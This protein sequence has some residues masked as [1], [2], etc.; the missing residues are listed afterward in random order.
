M[1]SEL[2][3]ICFDVPAVDD[4]GAIVYTVPGPPLITLT[5]TGGSG[6]GAFI[7]PEV[8]ATHYSND[9]GKLT[10]VYIHKE[11]SGYST[12]VSATVESP[13]I[14]TRGV[15]SVVGSGAGVS[16]STTSGGVTQVNVTNN[17]RS[18]KPLTRTTL[19][20]IFIANLDLNS[21]VRCTVKMTNQVTPYDTTAGT[22]TT[23]THLM[24][25]VRILPENAFFFDKPINMVSG[26]HLKIFADRANKLEATISFLEVF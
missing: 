12:S 10:A 20:S 21:T 23:Y 15:S 17:G 22:T 18:Y 24:K 19:H 5:D 8:N 1:A 9:F 25:N 4:T 14:Y 26:D 11:G 6:S 13:T 3:S 2:K 7:A 16:V